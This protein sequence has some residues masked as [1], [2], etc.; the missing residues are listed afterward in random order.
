M[1]TVKK[2]KKADSGI[3]QALSQVRC[4]KGSCGPGR[5]ERGPGIF[6]RIKGSIEEGRAR[7][8]IERDQR[9]GYGRGESYERDLPSDKAP[10]GFGGGE[11]LKSTRWSDK[12]GETKYVAGSGNMKKGGKVSKKSAP[13]KMVKKVAPKAKS[14]YKTTSKK[15]K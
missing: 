3:R 7:R 8:E 12:S 5:G 13:K 2:I 6:K 9:A 15:K 1:A 14:G 10:G 11:G 4:F